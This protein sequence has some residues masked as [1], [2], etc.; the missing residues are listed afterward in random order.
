MGGLEEI[1][2]VAAVTPATPFAADL[3][4]ALNASHAL[5]GLPSGPIIIPGGSPACLE[6]EAD[7]KGEGVS[8]DM[9]ETRQSK[10]RSLRRVNRF[11]S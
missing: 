9:M 5:H 7:G 6:V 8:A 2:A 10:R 3:V 4:N 11:V 1:A